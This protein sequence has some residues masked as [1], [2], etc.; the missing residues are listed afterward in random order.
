MILPPIGR[1]RIW[2]HSILQIGDVRS[3]T[4]QEKSKCALQIG[5]AVT[6]I[7]TSAAS[8]CYQQTRLGSE[9]RRRGDVE[10][11]ACYGSA[12]VLAEGCLGAARFRHKSHRKGGERME[13]SGRPILMGGLDAVFKQCRF[14]FAPFGCALRWRNS[15]GSSRAVAFTA[16]QRGP[17]H[18]VLGSGFSWGHCCFAVDSSW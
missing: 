15:A 3:D 13:R 8:M 5:Q 9:P 14:A 17:R 10:P 1:L 18:A 2:S 12:T 16:R 4:R 11:T 7:T 6:L